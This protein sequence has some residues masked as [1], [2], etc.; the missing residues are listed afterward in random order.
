M[1]PTGS[2]KQ[3]V[4][5]PIRKVRKSREC[6]KTRACGLSDREI[7]PARCSI[8]PV[9]AG[10]M[11]HRDGGPALRGGHGRGPA[12][13]TGL[14]LLVMRGARLNAVSVGALGVGA[15]PGRR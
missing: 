11:F 13:P 12:G 14:M 1:M 10:S 3:S 8:E 6:R 7:E 9:I 4:R 5:K 15:W 2:D